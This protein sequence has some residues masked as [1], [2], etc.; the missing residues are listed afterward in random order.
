[1]NLWLP[2]FCGTLS[3]CYIYPEVFVSLL[4]QS[5]KPFFNPIYS[6]AILMSMYNEQMD[7]LMLKR[8]GLAMAVPNTK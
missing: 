4:T 6:A 1:M 2:L 5:K 7:W 3:S 8:T